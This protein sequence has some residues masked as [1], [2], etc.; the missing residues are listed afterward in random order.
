MLVTLLFSFIQWVNV[1]I[2]TGGHGHTFPGAV[3]P[4]GMIQPSPDTR[5][6]GWDA[7]SG[8]HYSDS[9]INGFAQTH[10]SGTGGTDFGDFLLMPINGTPDLSYKGEKDSVQNV[11][12]ASSFSHQQEWASPGYYGVMLQRYGIKAEMT[13]TQRTALFRFTY[14][15]SCSEQTLV[16]DL[17][18]NIQE[19]TNLAMRAS[20]VDSVTVSGFKSS[21]WWAYRQDLHFVARFSKPIVSFQM[22]TDTVM[23][24]NGKK[25]P[26]CKA[27]IGFRQEKGN[28][29]PYS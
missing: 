13:A 4:N 3:V 7:C 17:D 2:G 8:Y 20:L 1:F 26:R 18:Y 29:D 12:Y 9:I 28:S 14:P 16:L 6:H 27:V 19:Q 5:I 10:L 21:Q 15:P 24:S 22:M 25:E 11:A 23:G